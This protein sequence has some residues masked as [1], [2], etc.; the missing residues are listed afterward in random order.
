[1]LGNVYNCDESGFGIEKKRATC[2]IVDDNLQK[3]YQAEPG[4]QEWV[5][6]MECICAN[7]SYVSLLIIF[8]GENLIRNWI[9]EKASE[10]W[11]V[12][13]NTLR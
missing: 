9:S 13:C 1:M 11:F 2:V 10:N 8:K 6:V 12:S 4:Q 3:A 5:T 7:G